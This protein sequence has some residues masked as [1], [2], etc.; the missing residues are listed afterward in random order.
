[1]INTGKEN[2]NIKKRNKKNN[3]EHTWNGT[4]Y[5]QIEVKITLG[6]RRASWKQKWPKLDTLE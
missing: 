6:C 5:K 4:N 3:K 2:N 1:M